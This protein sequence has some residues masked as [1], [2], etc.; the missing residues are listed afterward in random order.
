MQRFQIF[1]INFMFA[2]R[3]YDKKILNLENLKDVNGWAMSYDYYNKSVNP[4]L[5]VQWLFANERKFVYMVFL[6]IPTDF[7]F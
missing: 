5:I 3:E 2:K 7:G 4:F 6:N 1:W